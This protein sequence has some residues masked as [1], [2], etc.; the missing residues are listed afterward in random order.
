M[1]NGTFC[2]CR[3]LTSITIPESV[4]SI[5]NSAF[6]KCTGLKSIIISESVTF[7]GQDAFYNCISLKT[8]N[9]IGTKEQWSTISNRH[10]WTPGTTVNV[11][12]NYKPE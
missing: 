9:Y 3:R 7:I 10:Y 8:I 4:T 6:Y 11:I 1:G 5:G 2:Y 12:Y